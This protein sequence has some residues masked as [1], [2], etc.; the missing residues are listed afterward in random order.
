M[1]QTSGKRASSSLINKGANLANG[2]RHKP[3]GG[4][5]K[6]QHLAYGELEKKKVERQEH[7]WKENKK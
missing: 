6:G 4:K 2:S 5:W 1:Y 3:K 7:Q